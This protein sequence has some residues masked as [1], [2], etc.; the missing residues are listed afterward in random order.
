MKR[1][2]TSWARH[3]SKN[4]EKTENAQKELTMMNKK[5]NLI[6]L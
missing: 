6:T 2:S 5:I 3:F 1:C 4:N